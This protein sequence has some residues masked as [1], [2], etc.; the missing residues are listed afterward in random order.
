MLHAGYETS[1]HFFEALARY[2]LFEPFVFEVPLS[3]RSK[4]SLV[5]FHMINEDKLRSLDADA[6]GALQ[7]DGYLMPI[8]MAVASLSNL[9]ELVVRKNAKEDRG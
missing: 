3:N 2:D 6:L 9:T 1:K 7:A 5:G 8:F 4:Q